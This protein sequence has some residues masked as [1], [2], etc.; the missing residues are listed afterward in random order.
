[1]NVTQNQTVFN[2]GVCYLV[3]RVYPYYLIKSK[4]SEILK[5]YEESYYAVNYSNWNNEKLLIC[6]YRSTIST[7]SATIGNILLDGSL[8]YS[9]FKKLIIV[10]VSI[11]PDSFT[12]KHYHVYGGFITGDKQEPVNTFSFTTEENWSQIQTITVNLPTIENKPQFLTLRVF[13]SGTDKW[14]DSF[15]GTA[16]VRSIALST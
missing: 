14:G 7:G 4:Y 15:Y 13:N 5:K 1:V 10:G 6:G 16:N 9:K 11:N 2:N 8:N 12:I 3:K